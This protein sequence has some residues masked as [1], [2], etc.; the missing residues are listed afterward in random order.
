MESLSRRCVSSSLFT[1]VVLANQIASALKAEH[2][3]PAVANKLS[4]TCCS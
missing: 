2:P 4:R 3:D 1:R